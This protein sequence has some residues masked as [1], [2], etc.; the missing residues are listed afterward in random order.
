MI[1]CGVIVDTAKNTFYILHSIS[2]LYECDIFL[3][4]KTRLT[5]GIL[6]ISRVAINF[7]SSHYVISMA[8]DNLD[9]FNINAYIILQ[10]LN[11]T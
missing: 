7:N 3:I 2:V 11:K 8:Y 1:I 4:L 9:K 5:E 10:R 6:K